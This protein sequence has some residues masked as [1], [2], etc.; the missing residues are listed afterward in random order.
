MMNRYLEVYSVHAPNT[1][2]KRVKITGK[3]D[4]LVEKI[5]RELTINTDLSEYAIRIVDRPIVK[6]IVNKKM[7]DK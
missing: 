7:S 2:V 6:N 1:F 5:E 4:K 3:K